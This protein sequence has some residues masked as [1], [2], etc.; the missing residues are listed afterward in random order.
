MRFAAVLAIALLGVS[1]ALGQSAPASQAQ[2]ASPAGSQ[3]A[4]AEAPPAHP[5]TPQQ[6]HQIMELSHAETLARQVMQRE[7]AGMEKAFPPFMPK[8]VIS[9]LE[10]N[11]LSIDLEPMALKV[12]Q[13]HVSSEDA[14]QIIAFYKTPAGQRFLAAMPAITRE[15]QSRGAQEGEQIARQVIQ[16]H[17]DEIKAAA[18][19]Y[20]DAHAAPPKIINPN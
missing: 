7:F 19:K 15:M 20:K 8:D 11:L 12:Y 16:T 18:Q 10:H 4:S 9:E 13:E 1:S 3:T 5:I 6:V 17:M 2:P 14:V